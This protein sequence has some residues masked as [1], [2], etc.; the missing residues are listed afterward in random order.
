MFYR[1][2]E[3]HIAIEGDLRPKSR[4]FGNSVGMLLEGYAKV[5]FAKNNENYLVTYPNMYARGILFG[6]MVLELGETSTVTCEE[7]DLA[8]DVE[9]KTKG[10]IWGSYNQI[11]GKIRRISTREVLYEISGNWQTQ[12]YILD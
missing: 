8:F 9:F 10:I 7:S 5:N 12:I 4:F 1:S 11:A 2:P 3:H 6:K